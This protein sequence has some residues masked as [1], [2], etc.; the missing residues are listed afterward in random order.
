MKSMFDSGT[1]LNP[2]NLAVTEVDLPV[3]KDGEAL[4]K[5]L[6]SSVNRLDL[7]QAQGKAPVPP[8][9]TKIGGLDVCGYAVDPVSLEPV[10]LG[11]DGKPVLVIVLVSGGAYGQYVACDAE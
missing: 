4:V 2:A 6:S 8:G 3:C 11:A 10:E 7:L 9:V 1:A 5:V